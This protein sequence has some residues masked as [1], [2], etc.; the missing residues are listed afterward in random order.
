MRGTL[1]LSR[2]AFI[3]NVFFGLAVLVKM[4]LPLRDEA[5]V[6]TIVIA[7]YFL[8]ALFNPLVNIV[9]LVLLLR[10]KLAQLPRWL[11]VANF[12]FLL[13]Q[14]QYIFFLNDHSNP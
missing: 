11:V 1:F 8:V 4:G 14:I 9:Y 3:C 2:V 10:K 12:I 5:M 7:G 6:S 13:L